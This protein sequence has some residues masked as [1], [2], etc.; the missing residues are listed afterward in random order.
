MQNMRKLLV[1]L[2]VG[3]AAVASACSDGSG[4]TSAPI[5]AP[6][7]SADSTTAPKPGGGGVTTNSCICPPGGVVTTGSGGGVCTCTPP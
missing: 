7:M 3:T 4:P 2:V 5:A 6:R 1:A